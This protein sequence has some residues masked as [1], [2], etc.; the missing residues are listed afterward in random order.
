M[1]RVLM[2]L[3][4]AVLLLSLTAAGKDALRRGEEVMQQVTD[5]AFSSLTAQ[6]RRT[7]H[8]L[9]LR[10]LGEPVEIA[11]QGAPEPGSTAGEVGPR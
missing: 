11:E 5:E 3:A 10:A 9:A 6:K 8:Q 2:Q 4:A 7:L 1:K